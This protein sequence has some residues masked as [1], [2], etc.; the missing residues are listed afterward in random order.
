MGNI[1][2]A[3]KK[4]K[5]EDKTAKIKLSEKLDDLKLML[6]GFNAFVDK[7]TNPTYLNLTDIHR[8]TE[9]EDSKGTG[10]IIATVF[11]WKPRPTKS[12]IITTTGGYADEHKRITIPVAK[13][14]FS[15]IPHI[16]VGDIVRLYDYKV[17]TR[18][19]PRYEAFVDP[20]NNKSS[21]KRIGDAPP[22]KI[23]NTLVNYQH[24]M[25]R[26]NPLNPFLT[27]EDN[28]TFKFNQN[29]LLGGVDE[30]EAYVHELEDI[31]EALE[32]ETK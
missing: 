9:S 13:V 20:N 22:A 24:R 26:P 12:T 3:A 7:D 28:Y 30:V 19:N 27:E 21:G 10:F 8:N 16:E 25:V 1:I 18:Y 17:G 2:G 14:Q 29:D 6:K 5:E 4:I 31:M 32:K 15:S 11:T 23:D